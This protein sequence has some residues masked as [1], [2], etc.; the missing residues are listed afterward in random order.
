MRRWLRATG[1]RVATEE[2]SRL[3]Y[4]RLRSEATVRFLGKTWVKAGERQRFRDARI[5]TKGAK[6]LKRRWETCR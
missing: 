1:E 5:A 2:V 6:F 3:G 4:A